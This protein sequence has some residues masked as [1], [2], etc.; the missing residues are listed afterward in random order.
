MKKLAIL[1]GAAAVVLAGCSGQNKKLE[2]DSAKILSL[3]NE[4][5]QATDYKDSLMLLMGDI[6]IGLDSI[7]IQEG[8]LNNMG[9]GDNANRRAEIRN[10]LNSIRQ[11]LAANKALLEELEGKLDKSK[12]ENAVMAKTIATMKRQISEQS[13]RIAQLEGE[14][15][16]ARG[17]ID[18]LN[19]QVAKTQEEKEA[20]TAEKEKAQQEAIET[21]NALNKCYYAIGTNKELK[22]NGLLEKKFLSQ[23]KVLRGNFNEGYFTTADKRTLTTIPC[24]SNKVKIWTNHPAGSYQLIENANKTKTL[25]ITDPAKFWSLSDHLIIQ[26]G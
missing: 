2:E 16:T 18:E 11:R 20:E 12:G 7:N 23:T 10:N 1:L 24:N 21:A 4:L 3:Q 17:Q 14:L 5:T 22:K 25:K 19:T 9:T 13:A 15:T 8:M 6:Y 26:I